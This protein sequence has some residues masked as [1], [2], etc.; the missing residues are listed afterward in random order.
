MSSKMP[1]AVLGFAVVLAGTSVVRGQEP[2]PDAECVTPLTAKALVRMSPC[3][4]EAIYRQAPPGPIPV[5]Y[6]PG[7]AIWCAGTKLAVPLC[8]A[9]AAIWQGKNFDPCTMIMTNKNWVPSTKAKVFMGV[10]W[11][12]GCPSIIMD[13]A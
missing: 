4:L 5:G 11:F 12:D 6:Y 9:S 2:P 1:L 7:K 8:V 10:S 13:Y 3:Q